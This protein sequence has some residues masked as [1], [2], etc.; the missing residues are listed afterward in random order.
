MSLSRRRFFSAAAAGVAG[1]AAHTW[2]RRRAFASG[3]APGTVRRL[4]ILHAGGGMRS[5]CLFNAGVAPQWNPFGSIAHGD[6]D[7][8][9]KPLLA[10]GVGWSPG[11]L[12]V[13][14]RTPVTLT[15]WGS[16]TKLPIVTQVADKI[17]VLGSVDHDPN[18]EGDGNHFSATLRMCTGAPDGRVGLLTMFG[19]EL[20]GRAPLPPV[21]VGGSGPIGASVFGVGD[22]AMARYRPILINGPT[23][24]RYPRADLA[25]KDPSFATDLESALDRAFVA[26]RPHALDGRPADWIVA[27]QLGGQYGAHLTTDALRVAYAPT[28]ALGTTTDGQPLT[29]EMLA[30]LFGVPLA[31]P[32]RPPSTYPADPA[33]GAPTALGVRMLQLGAPVVAVGVGGWDFHSDEEKGLPKLAA[34]LGRAL[35]ALQFLLSRTIDPD[36]PGKTLW[37]TTLILVTSEFCRDN[38]AAVSDDGQKIGFNRGDGSDHHATSACRTQALPIMGGVIPG[39]RLLRPTDAQVKPREGAIATPSLLATLMQAMGVDPKPYFDHDPNTEVY[40]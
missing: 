31:A 30:E 6:V 36:V 12:L 7:T 22:G 32:G 27:K 17:S 14:D 19:K 37:D 29:N 11:A 1:V 16:T 2:L 34:S 5:T 4:L 39:G 33:W 8:E 18:A 21:I 38:T 35:A 9:G 26:S 15:T 40:G 25:A 24:F 20:D 28:A 13:G 3:P 10:P 23:D